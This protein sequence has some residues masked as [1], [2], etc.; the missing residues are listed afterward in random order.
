MPSNRNAQH[1]QNRKIESKGYFADPY[2]A[3]Q[4]GTSENSNGLLREFYHNVLNLSRVSQKTR[5]RN[6]SL[7]N[8]RPR[9]FLNYIFAQD[10]FNLE[11][12]IFLKVLRF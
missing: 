1:F 2:C 3:W 12:Q 9:K 6:L 5:L 10:S 7:I 4:K 11:L 8:N